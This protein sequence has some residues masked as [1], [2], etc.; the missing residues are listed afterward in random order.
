VRIVEPYL[1]QH[2]R[3]PLMPLEEALKGADIVV[4]LVAHR[5]FKTISP[6]L[7]AEK[8]IIDVCGALR[9]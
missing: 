5:P 8:T 6:H 3:Y 4:V 7:L 1:D 9:G 2:D